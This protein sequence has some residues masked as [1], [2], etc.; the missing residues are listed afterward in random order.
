M[1]RFI[2]GL[3]GIFKE[4]VYIFIVSSFILIW[5]LILLNT[6][7]RITWLGLSIFIFGGGL[8][9]FVLVLLVISFIKPINQVKT[10]FFVI[11]LIIGFILASLLMNS[12]YFPTSDIFF[13]ITLI[14]N[15]I[16]TAFFAF[17]ICMDSTTKID[18][19]LYKK[20]KSRVI[21][22]SIEFIVFGFLL[23]WI[24][25]ITLIFFSQ[26]LTILFSTVI[27]I[28][29]ILFWV[30]L[31]L[32]IIVILKLIVTKKFSAYITLFFLLT[33]CYVL[34]ILLDSI[35]G[36]FYST[37]SGD[38]TYII[39]SFIFDVVLFFY[40]IGTVYSRV[41]YITEK[42]KI[43]KVDTIAL[44]LILMRIYV[45]ISKILPRTIL[46]ELKILQATGLFVIFLFC[47]LLLGI[48]SIIAHKPYKEKKEK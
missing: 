36:A 20:G 43:F 42:L 41:D 38:L 21:T 12:I 30:Y 18:D 48:H 1:M 40:M 31:L 34:Y 14:A 23:W 2:T 33:F 27:L 35:F 26:T 29:Q 8:L 24:M 5:S 37:E 7:L 47:T 28:I 9:L 22:R 3:K 11:L 25:R 15:Q 39:I 44:F 45:Q 6:F 46:D 13:L 16:F 10:Y 32:M 19:F 4:P 17:K